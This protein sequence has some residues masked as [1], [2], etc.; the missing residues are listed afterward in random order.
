MVV[1]DEDVPE[2]GQRDAGDYQLSSDPVAAIDNIGRST[3][4]DDLRCR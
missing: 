1:C 3:P 2:R 4:Y